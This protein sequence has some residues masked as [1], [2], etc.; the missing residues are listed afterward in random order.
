M[1]QTVLD[2]FD[3]LLKNT[4]AAG[5]IDSAVPA[6]L[7]AG[8]KPP[9]GVKPWYKR[10]GMDNYDPKKN[11]LD[12][13]FEWLSGDYASSKAGR[14]VDTIGDMADHMTDQ[15]DVT[16]H[17]LVN[18]LYDP[19][20]RQVY[21]PIDP[22]SQIA[23]Q[24]AVADALKAYEKAVWVAQKS[25]EDITN[26]AM[27]DFGNQRNIDSW[28]QVLMPF[29]Y[30]WSRMWSR[31]AET[32]LTKPALMNFYYD[33]K[34]NIQ[35][36]NLQAGVPQRLEGTIPNP[37]YVA[38]NAINPEWANGPAQE[39]LTAILFN[40]RARNP[41]DAMMNPWSGYFPS[42]FID[43]DEETTT[44]GNPLYQAANLVNPEW[45]NGPAQQGMTSGLFNEEINPGKALASF[46]KYTGF[47]IYP[48]WELALAGLAALNGDKSKINDW[49]MGSQL[50]PLQ[51]L[52][53]GFVGATGNL[54]SKVGYNAPWWGRAGDQWDLGR[55]GRELTNSLV[56][57]KVSP[58][59]AAWG[60][61]IGYQIQ[62]EVGPLPEQ[63]KKAQSVWETAAQRMGIN[64]LSA[65][66]GSTML[67]LGIY[68]YPASEKQAKGITTTYNALGADT[69]VLGSRAAMTGFGEQANGLP[70]GVNNRDVVDVSRMGNNLYPRM[71]DA[72]ST[73]VPKRP[74]VAQVDIE[75]SKVYD[76]YA[77]KIAD[78]QAQIDAA[79]ARGDKK[80]ASPLY[81]EKNALYDERD[82]LLEENFPS[83]TQYGTDEY[84]ARQDAQNE[85]YD[86]YDKLMGDAADQKN[87]DTY[88][89][90]KDA[91]CC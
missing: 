61:D 55:V 24:D 9:A 29:S 51:A 1:P 19:A 71:D 39:G 59:L 52:Y 63:P 26:W 66:F 69:N 32:A 35:R 77:A 46:Q 3:A 72:T 7:K 75:T 65:I 74:G 90:L 25:A 27:M 70:D 40:E 41:I 67:G 64:R 11:P 80:A 10:M 4:R 53:Y 84:Q 23:V 91:T 87:W 88:Y 48:G 8:A 47:S 68:D 14:P 57:G 56:E 73:F 12:Q 6:T 85:I 13:I 31:G 50:W 16:Y 30:Y 28:L 82:T 76:E 62:N 15:L 33:A 36:E 78:V 20:Y 83:R 49:S 54:D 2:N 38:A 43:L 79:T 5:K 58:E 17:T 21:K 60:N 18:S 81:D 34:R 45:A 42:Q 89:S 44:M 22:S 37:L 86:K